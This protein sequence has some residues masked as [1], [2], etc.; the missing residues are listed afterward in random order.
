MRRRHWWL[1]L[2]PLPGFYLLAALVGSLVPV[3]RGW[4]E[5]EQGITVYLADNGI[6]ADLVMPARA[7]G[8]DW[9]PLVPKSDFAAP[10]RRRSL[11][12]VRSG[13][14]AGLSGDPALA[15]H[16]ARGRSGRR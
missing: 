4:A 11:D 8:L 16:H 2:A 14:G 3:N 5:P 7:A 9:T 10:D 15:R 1:A 6:H 13:R 12:G